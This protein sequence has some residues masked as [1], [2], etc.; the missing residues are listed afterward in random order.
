MGGH[1]KG[2][3][4]ANIL[5]LSDPRHGTVAGRVAHRKMGDPVCARCQRAIRIYNATILSRFTDT[6]LVS[7]LG[8]RRRV[9][10]LACI[11]W[12]APMLAREGGWK[13]YHGVTDVFLIEAINRQ[14]AQRISELFDRLCMTPAPDGI[15]SAKARAKAKRLGWAP[16]LAWDDIDNDAAP[17]HM[18]PSR[19]TWASA[20]LISEA[21]HLLSLG[22][23]IEQTARKLGVKPDAI[24]Q[25]R[26]RA[27]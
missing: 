18:G 23:S 19:K 25:A 21:D 10:A 11:G 8:A 9:Q 2:L 4:S 14:T 20:D 22:E 3:P 1:T 7:S 16:P 15:G 26:S 24:E 12:S 17:A 13:S 6:G 27:A 5:N